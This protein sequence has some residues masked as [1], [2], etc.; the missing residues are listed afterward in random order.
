MSNSILMSL[1]AISGF[2]AYAWCPERLPIPMDLLDLFKSFSFGNMT[3]NSTDLIVSGTFFGD[4]SDDLP[5]PN[6]TIPPQSLVKSYVNMNNKYCKSMFPSIKWKPSKRL[7]SYRNVSFPM[8]AYI[9][10]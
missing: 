8:Y 6:R 9:C 4:Y 10:W 2:L 5:L 7:H 1:Q 3:W